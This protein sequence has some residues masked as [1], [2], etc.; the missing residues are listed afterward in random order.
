MFKIKHKIIN[1]LTINNNNIRSLK[2]WK[3]ICIHSGRKRYCNLNRHFNK[4]NLYG[5]KLWLTVLNV[6]IRGAE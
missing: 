2:L 5:K 3:Y 6:C 4:I 1:I